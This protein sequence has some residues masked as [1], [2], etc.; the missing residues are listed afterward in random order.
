MK[1]FWL[2]NQLGQLWVISVFLDVK[3]MADSRLRSCCESDESNWLNQGFFKVE[4]A[5][6]TMNLH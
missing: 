2:E 1:Y 5:M 4:S 3:Q 6:M